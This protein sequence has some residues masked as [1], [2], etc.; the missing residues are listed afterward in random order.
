MENTTAT[1]KTTIIISNLNKKDFVGD[2]SL[3]KNMSFVDQLKLRILNLPSPPGTEDSSNSNY[4]LETICNW[5]NLSFSNRVIIIMKD[6]RLAKLLYDY[7][8]KS[9]I[10]P[11]SCKLSLQENLLSRSKSFDSLE[12]ESR[13]AHINELKKF[14]ESHSDDILGDIGYQ[15]PE[16]QHFDASQY[17]AEMR[18]GEADP[19]LD[20]PSVNSTDNDGLKRSDSQTKTLFKPSLKINTDSICKS[21][22]GY[23]LSP[24]IT[25]DETF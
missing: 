3:A 11:A 17:V 23:I 14:K 19:E 13:L 18:N 8:Q 4:F 1:Q 10:L 9:C 5:S 22:D 15:E 21:H 20:S 25:L 7:L 2:L 16:P 12:V 24:T 6:E